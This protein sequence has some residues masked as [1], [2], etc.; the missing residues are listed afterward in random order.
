M[1]E[2]T[3]TESRQTLDD[4]INLMIYIDNNIETKLDDFLNS[5]IN[6][7]V[8]RLNETKANRE[9]DLGWNNEL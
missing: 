3:E 4:F 8:N 1:I 7:P 5:P 2:P 6:T 9:L